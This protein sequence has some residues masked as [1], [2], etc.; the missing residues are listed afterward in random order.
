MAAIAATASGDQDHVNHEQHV[1]IYMLRLETWEKE[2][3][4][5]SHFTTMNFK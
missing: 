5:G 4:T 1:S 2:S 3:L